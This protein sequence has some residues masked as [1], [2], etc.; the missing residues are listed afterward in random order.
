MDGFRERRTCSEVCKVKN[1]VGKLKT[2]NGGLALQTSLS[3]NR[4]IVSYQQISCHLKIEVKMSIHYKTFAEGFLEQDR[5]GVH[6]Q[7]D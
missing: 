3:K 7:T 5:K 1:R 2:V 6:S 4:L